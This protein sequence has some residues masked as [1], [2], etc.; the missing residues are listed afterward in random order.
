MTIEEWQMMRMFSTVS[1]SRAF[2]FERIEADS[3]DMLRIVVR[4][5]KE[6]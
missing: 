5:E 1:S 3:T 6:N 2:E 4:M